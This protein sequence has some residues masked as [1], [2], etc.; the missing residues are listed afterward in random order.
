MKM[1]MKMKK[2]ENI[3]VCIYLKQI[4]PNFKILEALLKTA[5][6]KVFMKIKMQI[7]LLKIH[8]TIKAST[9]VLWKIIIIV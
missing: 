1:K 6:S 2:E 5:D 3:K 8:S 7:D 4:K 9:K